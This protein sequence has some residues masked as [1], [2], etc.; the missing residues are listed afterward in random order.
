MRPVHDLL[1]TEVPNMRM[2]LIA[3]D[4]HGPF[5]DVDSRCALELLVLVG[6]EAVN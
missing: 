6:C 2:H 4:P 3:L 1:S 5:C